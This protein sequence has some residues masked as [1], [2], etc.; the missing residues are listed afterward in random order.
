MVD[1]ILQM[2]D[3]IEKVTPIV[4]EHL[5]KAQAKQAYHYN[6]TARTR[7]FSPGH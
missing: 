7:V 3:R 4:R 6:K 2:Q 5:E 1:Y